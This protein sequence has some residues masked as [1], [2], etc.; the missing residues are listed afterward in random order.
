MASTYYVALNG[1]DTWSGL[2]AAPNTAGTDGPLATFGAAQKKMQTTAIKSTY[3][4]GGTYDLASTL[5]LGSADVGTTWQGYPGETAV[6]R[7]GKALTGWTLDTASGLWSAPVA[8]ASLPGGKLGALY[9][10]GVALTPA[11]YPNAVPT[12]PVKGGWRFADTA[13]AGM[14]TKAQFRFKAG[15]IPAG[16]AATG[17]KVNIWDYDGWQDYN[18]DVQAIDWSTN[19]VTLTTSQSSTFNTGSRYFVY[20]AKTL[21]DGPGEWYFDAAAGRV[22]VK[23]PTA[24]FD[25]SKVSMGTLG[26]IISTY[27]ASNITIRNLTLGEMSGLGTVMTLNNSTGIT[28]TGNVFRNADMGL[29][30][31]GTTSNLSVF[32]NQFA[33]MGSGGIRLDQSTNATTINANWFHDIGLRQLN[34]NAVWMAGSSNNIVGNNLFERIAKFAIGGGSTTGTK[35]SYNNVIE[36]NRIDVS[37]MHAADGGAIMIAGVQGELANDVIRYNE[38][39]GTSAAG[40]VIGWNN[41]I[42]TSFFDPMKLTSFAIYLDDYASGITVTG[43]VLHDNLGG[44]LVHGGRQNTITN[45]EFANN[46]GDAFVGSE[47]VWMNLPLPDA[48][49]NNFA[50]NIVYMSTADHR[51]VNLSGVRAMI[52]SNKNLFGGA[53]VTG[54]DIF[55]AWPALMST[56]WKGGLTQWKAAGFDTASTSGNPLFTNLAAGDFSLA[57]TS[58]AFALGFTAI[59]TTLIGL[60]DGSRTQATLAAV[61]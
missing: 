7:G 23:A 52:T 30:A 33:S 54:V 51:A 26:T 17:L 28:V 58:P 42:N 1:R 13:T 32:G 37:N 44:V 53:N 39:S 60:P 19:T 49:N 57:P 25:P 47:D 56:G 22:Y 6:L 29:S 43:N 16:L 40:T 10:G 48:R 21:L 27:A 38:I 8:A 41:T 59:P 15:D 45:N 12:D 2:L 55:R 4:R 9:L 50:T 24:G 46:R 11:R 34:G 20:N 3:V 35:A 61:N 31:M 36:Y 5:A 14:N 18:A